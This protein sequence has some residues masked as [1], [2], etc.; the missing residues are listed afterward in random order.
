MYLLDTNVIS[1]LMR[2]E[3]DSNVYL[4]VESQSIYSL[5]ITA[6]TQAEI[7]YGLMLLPNGRRKNRLVK[8]SESMFSE[9][10][11]GRILP[12]DIAAASEYANV[13]AK[14]PKKGH[15]I[16][17]FDAQIAGIARSRGM[18][19]VTCN[20]NDFKDCDIP[21]INPWLHG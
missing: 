2:P 21:L 13:A 16:S 1:E 19:I 3:P 14:K 4:W 17:Q 6:I 10:F 5:F 11:S 15:P 12:F 9:D 18:T 20:V 8:T 7:L